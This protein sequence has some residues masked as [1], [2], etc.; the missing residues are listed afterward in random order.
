MLDQLEVFER[1]M[2]KNFDGEDAG[3]EWRDL[4]DVGP[5]VKGR[6]ELYRKYDVSMRARAATEH[7]L[8]WAANAN[9]NALVF[10]MLERIYADRV[11]LAMLREEIAPYVQAVQH[12]SGFAISEMPRLEEFDVEGLC[13]NCPLLKS[14]YIECLRVDTASWSLK[15]VRQDFVLSTRDKEAQ[16]WMLKKGEYV[17]VAHDLHNTDPNVFEHPDMWK[18][19]RHVK[20]ENGKAVSAD[21]GSIRPYGKPTIATGSTMVSEMLMMNCR[22]RP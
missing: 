1:A 17:H 16:K 7:A 11:L 13:A 4:D 12:D 9:S 18:P 19:D 20:Y 6:V 3:A 10:W 22:W 15:V 5:V 8:M 14:C 2:E 21:M